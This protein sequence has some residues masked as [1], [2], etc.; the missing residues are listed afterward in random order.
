MRKSNRVLNKL[1]IACWNIDG[2][3]ARQG[4]DR[5][6]KLNSP[7]ICSLLTKHDII[8]LVETHCNS[9]DAL[10][11]PGYQVFQKNTSKEQKSKAPLWRHRCLTK[12]R[13]QSWYQTARFQLN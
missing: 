12:E 2:V 13:D 9:D 5:V 3:H 10:H 11:L 7:D 4:N 8:G 1:S 6:C